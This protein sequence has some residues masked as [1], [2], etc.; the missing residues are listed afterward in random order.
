MSHQRVPDDW[1]LKALVSGVPVS[2]RPP[3]L[4]V[5]DDEPSVREVL[6]RLFDQ[7]GWSVVTVG[8]GEDAFHHLLVRQ[9]D[10]WMI[11]KHLP[12]MAGLA[13][14]RT[15]RTRDPEAITVLITGYPVAAVATEL[16]GVVDDYLAKPFELSVVRETVQSLLHRRA[17]RR[18]VKPT[19]PR[20][21]GRRTWVHLLTEDTRDRDVLERALASLEAATTHG[22][23][24]SEAPDLLVV[25]GA[26]CTLSVREQIWALQDRTPTLP[27]VV[28]AHP[29]S[30]NDASA[31]IAVR[32]RWSLPHPCPFRVLQAALRP[33][34]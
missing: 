24:P 15:V 19:P 21:R 14:C 2:D 10:V 32:A 27:V 34:P 9:F 3:S 33:A 17:T 31:V 5:V 20:A 26:A 11:D 13:L 29:D 7:L 23:I 30:V 22:P 18:T 16:V 28:L 1:T 6:G 8:S 12:A 4:I 25:A